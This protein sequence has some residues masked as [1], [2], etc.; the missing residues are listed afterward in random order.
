MNG[1]TTFPLSPAATQRS[2]DFREDAKYF[3][4]DDKT[5]CTLTIMFY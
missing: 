5:L 2:W 4:L 1:M 3:R